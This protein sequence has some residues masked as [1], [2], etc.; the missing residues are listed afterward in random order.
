MLEITIQS[1]RFSTYIQHT[2]WPGLGWGTWLH[3][4]W[5]V[6]DAN[7]H[8]FPDESD[9]LWWKKVLRQERGYV[10][11]PLVLTR[12]SFEVKVQAGSYMRA[13]VIHRPSLNSCPPNPPPSHEWYDKMS[14]CLVALIRVPCY[15]HRPGRIALIGPWLGTTMIQY[16]WPDPK[17]YRLWDRNPK[18]CF[19]IANECFLFTNIYRANDNVSSVCLNSHM[20]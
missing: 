9:R 14:N 8:H 15:S 11:M 6:L 2:E 7:H 4:E 19:E 18:C 5:L 1:G 17:C 16:S 13:A 12:H 3:T 10:G 20:T